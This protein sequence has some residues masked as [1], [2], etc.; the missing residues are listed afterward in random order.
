MSRPF[1]KQEKKKEE[2]GGEKLHDEQ[3]TSEKGASNLEKL[4]ELI[5]VF[6]EKAWRELETE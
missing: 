6:T 4:R 5:L 2:E 3:G 1:K